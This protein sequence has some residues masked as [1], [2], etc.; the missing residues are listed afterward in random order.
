MT[1]KFF[2]FKKTVK[3][4]INNNLKFSLNEQTANNAHLKISSRFS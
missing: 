4:S 2:E 1:V 3:I